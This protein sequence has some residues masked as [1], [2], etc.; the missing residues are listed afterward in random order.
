MNRAIARLGLVM[1]VG[2]TVLFLQLNNIQ[3]IGAERLKENPENNRAVVRDFGQARGSIVTAD[4]AVVARSVEV[5]GQFEHARQY[6]LGDLFG[7]VAGYFSFNF[8]SSGVER[9]YHDLLSGETFEQEISSLGDLFLDRERTADVVLTLRQDLQEVARDAL[10][11]QQGSVVAIDPR[12]G[13][14][15]AM[16]TY[17]SYDPG[18]LSGLDFQSANEARDALLDDDD[19]PLLPRAYREIFFPGST[20]KIVTAAAALESGSVTAVEPVYPF[21]DEFVP[22]LTTRGLSNFGGATCGGN[23][24][25]AL[26]VSCNTTFAQIGVELGPDLLVGVAESFGF[27]SVPPVDLPTPEA[28]VFPT[29]YGELLS[30]A[31]EETPY[32]IYENTPRLAQVAI[33]QN[34]VAATPLQMALVAAAVANDGV[35]MKPRVVS[36]VRDLTGDV[37]RSN[38]PEQ[39]QRAVSA[40]TATTLRAGMVGVVEDGTAGRLAIDG[41]LVGGK[42]GTAQLGTDPPRSHAWI[43]G[44]AGPQGELPHVAVGVIVEGQEGASEQ[45]GGR[46]AAP[47]AQQVMAAALA[48]STEPEN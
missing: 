7:H 6:P 24:F 27:N 39:W 8:G 16:W 25:E 34:D 20:F 19:N 22:P 42:T 10:G 33:G 38:S 1:M 2:Y 30:A 5:V 4:G 14:V 23:L 40:P 13:S 18:P 17:P 35:V 41:F 21:V 45:T 46:V 31:D 29:D 37:V 11:E 15:L 32:A 44:F 36:E 48:I 47:I 9:E 26:R 3:L 12:D 28:S 43:I